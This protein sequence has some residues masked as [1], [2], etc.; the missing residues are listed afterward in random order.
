MKTMTSTFSCLTMALLATSLTGGSAWAGILDTETKLTASDA[1]TND[2]FGRSVAISGN[3]A[4]VGA[5][6][7]DDR[8]G[9]AYLFDFTTGNQ[10]AKLTADDAAEGDWFGRSVAISGNTVLVGA[11]GD[12]FARGSAYL[13]NITTGNQ[14][15]KLTAFD[16]AS[17]DEFG[18]SVAINGN[19]ALIGAPG[20]E[21]ISSGSAYLF[22]I[23]TGNQ[24]AKLT[25]DDAA[26][27]DKFGRS[28]AISGNTALV[29]NPRDDDAGS[30]SG[31][32][33]LFDITTGSQI[34]K[35]T[36]SD[37]A[38]DDL[39][40]LSVAISGNTAIVGAHSNDDAGSFSGSAYL[41]NIT[42]GNQI[43]KLTASDAAEGNF[44]GISVSISGN[45]ALVG[46]TGNDDGGYRSGSA[47]LFDITTSSQIA[48]LTASDAATYDYFGN[49][50]AISDNKALVGAYGNDDAGSFSG[51][52]YLYGPVP[53]P[54][55]FALALL[56]LLPLVLCRRQS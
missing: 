15:A 44:F 32:A 19:T 42:T 7:D 31:S 52:A 21:G 6:G 53:E 41:F 51:S 37:A 49:S 25:A 34:A 47:Y 35:L 1:A 33:Y 55:G 54:S 16:A 2:Y 43:A 36:A 3:T 38:T 14:I 28:V 5:F 56:G 48:K 8:A 11:L 12:G 39:F 40:G 20:D 46:A 24:I 30:S 9:S 22:D 13:F 26:A 10:I 17:G 23:T 45:T 29:G 27:Y 4:L 18:S 50:V